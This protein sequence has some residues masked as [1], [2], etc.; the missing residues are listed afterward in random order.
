MGG[1]RVLASRA[2]PHMRER[3]GEEAD[4]GETR[5]RPTWRHLVKHTHLNSYLAPYFHTIA[6][7]DERALLS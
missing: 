6:K 4:R 5:E 1:S 3:R 7:P 2:I